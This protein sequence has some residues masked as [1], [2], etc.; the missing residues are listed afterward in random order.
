MPYFVACE[1][2]GNGVSV[3]QS[4]SPESIQ[5]CL[6]SQETTAPIP[7]AQ[8]RKSCAHSRLIDEVLAKDGTRTGRVSCYECSAVFED[9]GRSP[10]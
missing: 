8:S 10:K 7:V 3:L 1:R 6:M 2:F 5:R 9:L 4:T